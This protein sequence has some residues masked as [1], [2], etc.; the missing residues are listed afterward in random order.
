MALGDALAV[1]LIRER[2]FTA[3]DFAQHHPGG[4]LGRALVTKVRDEMRIMDLPIVE[5]NS[6]VADCVCTMT[7]GRL[8]LA[9][10]LR[11]DRVVG[12]VTDG[13]LRRSLPKFPDLAQTAVSQIMT[14]C[15]KTI[16]PDV[17]TVEAEARMQREKVKALIVVDDFGKLLGVFD[18]FRK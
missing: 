14:P 17:I 8:G 9:V 10:V 13:D 12:I 7:V 1:T 15:P 5:E 3:G 18:I 2:S 6:S 11:K 16:S 4:N